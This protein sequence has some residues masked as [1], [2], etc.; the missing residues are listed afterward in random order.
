MSPETLACL[1]ARARS[2]KLTAEEQRVIGDELSFYVD[3]S[4]RAERSIHDVVKL[5]ES[6]DK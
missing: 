5:F 1:I 3:A 6:L 4:R 2:G